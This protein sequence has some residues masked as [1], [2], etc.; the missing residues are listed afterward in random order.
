MI[1][2]TP[3][4]ESIGVF[5]ARQPNGMVQIDHGHF[6]VLLST[7]RRVNLSSPFPCVTDLSVM[8]NG[9]RK[10]RDG[11][12]VELNGHLV[13]ILIVC[14]ATTTAGSDGRCRQCPR[15]ASPKQSAKIVRS[16]RK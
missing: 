6:V 16:K 14:T 8:L 3:L 11:T 7:Q 12:L 2:L 15:A 10:V 9:Q 13:A 1:H 4:L 5:C